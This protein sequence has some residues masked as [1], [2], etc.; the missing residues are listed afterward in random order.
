[1]LF[2][3]GVGWLLFVL[4][5]KVVA[6]VNVVVVVVVVIVVCCFKLFCCLDQL[7]LSVPFQVVIWLLFVLENRCCG[8]H[9]LFPSAFSFLF[10]VAYGLQGYLRS[11]CHDSGC[12]CLMQPSRA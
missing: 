9:L 6:S 1:M 11:C 4:L 2:V 8:N 10:R 12:H 5:R 7:L 3:V